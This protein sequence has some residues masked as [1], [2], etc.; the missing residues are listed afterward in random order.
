MQG[1]SNQLGNI[2]IICSA[3]G[4]LDTASG[5][6]QEALK[7]LEDFRLMY[8][9]NIVL[10]AIEEIEGRRKRGMKKNGN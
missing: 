3:K 4:D 1:E 5:Y 10:R 8:G 7:I 6:L 9:K 2:G